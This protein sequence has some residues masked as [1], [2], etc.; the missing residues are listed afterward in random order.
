MSRRAAVL[1]VLLALAAVSPA[2]AAGESAGTAA[3]SFLAMGTG[4]SV[5]SM[6]GATVASGHDL[7]AA[8][9]NVASLA[10]VDALQFSF[11]HSPLPGGST[12]DWLAGGGRLGTGGTRWGMQALFQREGDIEGRDASNNPTGTLSASDLALGAS[13]AQPLGRYVTA[14]VGAQWVHESLAGT[15]GSGMSFDAGLR[16]DAGPVGVALAARGLGGV[17][18]YPGARY[19]LP[20]VIAA[21]VSWTDAERGL[22]LNADFETPRD[23]YNSVRVGGEW[24]WRDRIAF[25]AG[26]R[27]A[28]EAPSDATTSGPAFGMGAGLGTMWL[29]Y[30]FLLDGGTTS[31][32]HRIGLTFHPGVLQGLGGSVRGE[33]SAVEASPRREAAPAPLGPKPMAPALGP[34]PLMASPAPQAAPRAATAAPPPAPRA[35]ATGPATTAGPAASSKPLPPDARPNWIVVAPGE[36]LASLAT[37]WD[38]S[39]AALMMTNNLVSDRVSAGQQ[40]QLPAPTKH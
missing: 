14:G 5:L 6:A 36:T 30:A 22:R 29:D 11:A 4:T 2:R 35:T 20:Q 34:K 16:A 7:A 27:L 37:R 23:Y 21:G 10:R 32:E 25:R 24:T 33:R 17:M 31:G 18:R 38:T 40:L 1:S 13:L 9:W 19:D 8:S 28:L 3:G 26:Y 12:Q 15:D 39:V